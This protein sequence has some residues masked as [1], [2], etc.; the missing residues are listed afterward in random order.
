M[1][2]DPA[3]NLLQQRF[4]WS[5]YNNAGIA[6]VAIGCV[7]NHTKSLS[8]AK[9]LIIMPLVMH[10]ETT[11][12]LASRKTRSREIASLIAIRPDFASN[13]NSRYHSSLV[14][15]INAIQILQALGYAD[16]D[17]H[18]TQVNQFECNAELGKR[19]MLIEKASAEIANILS[20]SEEEL[21][22]NLRIEL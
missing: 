9:S 22:L 21:Y 17:S 10:S 14:H 19:A 2:A 8:L 5:G 4:F 13:F 18:V 20:S 15:S 12:F 6:A 3:N 16:F 7:L 1:N 11:R